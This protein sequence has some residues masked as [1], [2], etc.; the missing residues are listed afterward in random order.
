MIKKA[1][2]I[3]GLMIGTAMLSY[4]SIVEQNL[5]S[6]AVMQLDDSD[7]VYGLGYKLATANIQ[8]IITIV[9]MAIIIY[10]TFNYLRI[11]K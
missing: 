2:L 4:N 5:T 6:S 7:I 1:K 9:A 10:S 3:I 11:D 8:P